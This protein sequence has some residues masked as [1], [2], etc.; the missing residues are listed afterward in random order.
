MLSAEH[1]RKPQKYSL[2]REITICDQ[3][4][5]LWTTDV[6]VPCH[7]VFWRAHRARQIQRTSK[8]IQQYYMYTL[9]CLISYLLSN[10]FNSEFCKHISEQK[11]SSWDAWCGTC[12]MT[13]EVEYFDWLKKQPVNQVPS[14][15]WTIIYSKVV[16]SCGCHSFSKPVKNPVW[17]YIQYR[18]LFVCVIWTLLRELDNKYR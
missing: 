2:L 5:L 7:A 10:C 6:L 18:C 14:T 16:M 8:N 1:W 3:W 12:C 11:G 13:S 17:Y 4:N 9:K 15:E